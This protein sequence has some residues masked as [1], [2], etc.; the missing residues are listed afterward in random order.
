[1]NKLFQTIDGLIITVQKQSGNWTNRQ[2]DRQ[3][4]NKP[5]TNYSIAGIF[6]NSNLLNMSVMNTNRW[7]IQSIAHW[8]PLLILLILGSILG[9]FLP[10]S[11]GFDSTVTRREIQHYFTTH[12]GNSV[13]SGA[14]LKRFQNREIHWNG[15]IYGIKR[16]PASSRIELLIKVLPDSLLYDTVVVLEGNTLIDSFIQKGSPV[17]FQGK[18]FNGVDVLGVKEVQV[19]VR[20][21]RYIQ[22]DADKPV[23]LTPSPESSP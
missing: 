18:I 4:N 1:M 20:D 7:I 6:S 2:T 17:T 10:F 12:E 19:L 8:K 16:A 11:F 13:R 21:P 14:W 5:A 22:L 15:V 9:G 3:P 23:G